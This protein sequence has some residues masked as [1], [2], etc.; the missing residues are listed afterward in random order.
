MQARQITT[1]FTLVRHATGRRDADNSN[2][3][4]A[5]CGERLETYDLIEPAGRNKKGA[6]KG[7]LES[8]F[9]LRAPG[10]VGARLSISG[11]KLRYFCSLSAG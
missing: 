6:E 3:P 11:P 9:D 8:R 4:E 10:L 7:A 5:T 1:A 2:G